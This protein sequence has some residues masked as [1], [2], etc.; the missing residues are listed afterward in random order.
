M[1]RASEGPHRLT[2]FSSRLYNITL[3]RSFTGLKYRVR[4]FKSIKSTHSTVR[5]GI[6]LTVVVNLSG[7]CEQCGS[8][9]SLSQRSASLETQR[10]A[11]RA[12]RRHACVTRVRH[13]RKCTHTTYAVRLYIFK[14]TR[15]DEYI[16]EE[17]Q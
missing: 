2:H 11:T 8:V 5:S 14:S 13:N 1:P 7:W 15:F 4:S 12:P 16:V 6:L 3:T 9:R 17:T 10:A